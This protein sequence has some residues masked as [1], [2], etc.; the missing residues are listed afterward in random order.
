MEIFH[1]LWSNSSIENLKKQ[2]ISV[3]LLLNI[4][5]LRIYRQPKK[6]CPGVMNTSEELGGIVVTL[7]FCA[8]SIYSKSY[9]KNEKC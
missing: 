4:S 8:R 6:T 2:M 9:I 3:L 5:F 7:L 1:K